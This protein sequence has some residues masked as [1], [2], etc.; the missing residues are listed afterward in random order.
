TDGG[1][2][3]LILGPPGSS[4]SVDDVSLN[5]FANYSY[6]SQGSYIGYDEVVVID[7]DN[8]YTRN[9]FTSYG[10]DLNN[11]SHYDIQPTGSLGWLSGIDTYYPMN[12]L[13]NERGKPTGVFKYTSN[14]V[15]IQKT[16][17]TYRNDPSR[18]NNY[19]KLIN[20]NASYSQC[21][22]S[23]ALTLATANEEFNYDYYV[24]NQS[25][26]NYDQL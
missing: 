20:F 18:F 2:R 7:A 9:F 1:G 25:V 14:D 22:N 11:V 15:L 23:A 3:K 26:T 10:P 6:N 21:S 12:T 4:I 17:L 13:E 5:S 8:S 19:I 16:I 24:T